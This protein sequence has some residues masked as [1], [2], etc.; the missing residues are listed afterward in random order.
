MA[1]SKGRSI[2]KEPPPIS[3]PQSESMPVGAVGDCIVV[4][5]SDSNTS[6]VSDNERHL[7]L[8]NLKAESEVSVS[9]HSQHF[10]IDNSALN[11]LLHIL[12]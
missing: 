1:Q 7:P 8:S 9:V 2:I 4:A 6:N 12:T 10:P 5:P 11:I 3:S